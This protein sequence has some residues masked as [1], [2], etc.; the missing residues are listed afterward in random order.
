MSTKDLVKRE[1]QELLPRTWEPFRFIEEMEREVERLFAEPFSAWPR[2][3]T[4]FPRFMPTMPTL[5]TPRVDLFEK[6]GYLV[7]KAELPG[8]K[9]EEIEVEL[10]DGYLVIKGEHKGEHEVTEESFY[11]MERSYGKFFRRIPL[12]TEVKAEAISAT[13]NDGILEVRI[14]VPKVEKPETLKVKIA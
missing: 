6:D 8:L 1:E 3:L 12:P 4:R 11:R 14:L 7:A 9:K 5:F 13:Y 10:D 2:M